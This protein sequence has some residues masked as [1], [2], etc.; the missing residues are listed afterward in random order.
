MGEPYHEP[1]QLSCHR[2]VRVDVQGSR[3]TSAGGLM[4]VRALAAR[5]GMGA[6]LAPHLT[7]TRRGRHT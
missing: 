2:S 7:D 5:V 6:L 4:R 1:F 3:V